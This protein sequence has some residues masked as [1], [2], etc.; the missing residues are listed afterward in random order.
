MN[1]AP[2]SVP[3]GSAINELIF[4]LEMVKEPAK[5]KAF[6]KELSELVS[7]YSELSAKNSIEIYEIGKKK[8]EAVSLTKD[9]E[10]E[11]V[12]LNAKKERL[13][14]EELSLNKF[15]QELHLKHGELQNKETL[16]DNLRASLLD[17]AK[18]KELQLSALM[19]EADNVK[20]ESKKLIEEYQ[21]KLNKLKA[22]MG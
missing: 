9:H 8:E 6:L 18:F 22:V 12:E 20:V 14:I 17:D 1:M 11:R 4:I 3:S 10:A 5:T 19:A 2:L 21:D 15:K 13:S 7:E 16:L